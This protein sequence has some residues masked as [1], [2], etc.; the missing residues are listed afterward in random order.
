M[1]ETCPPR[2]TSWSESNAS[3]HNGFEQWEPASASGQDGCLITRSY[4]IDAFPERWAVVGD[5]LRR[6]V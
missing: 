6:G 1:C 2:E 3:S 5:H 4:G